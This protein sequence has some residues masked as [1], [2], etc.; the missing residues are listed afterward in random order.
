MPCSLKVRTELFYKSSDLAHS[1]AFG[2]VNGNGTHDRGKRRYRYISTLA[3]TSL[4]AIIMLCII[5]VM[6]FLQNCET[7]IRIMVR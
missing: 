7:E 5:Y 1:Q 6:F 4:R 3:L 2:G